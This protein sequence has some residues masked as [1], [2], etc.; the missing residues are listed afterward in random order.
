MDSVVLQFFT[1]LA[2][3][4]LGVVLGHLIGR[5]TSSQSQ[6]NREVERKLDQVLQDKK[7]YEDEVAEHFTDTARLLNSLTA[8]Y[9]EVHTHLAA[10]AAELCQGPVAMAQLEE[11]R[12]NTEIPA[13]L[14][15]V[16]AP[17][18]YAPKTSPDEKGML[19]ET[20]GLEKEKPA[21]T[22]PEQAAAQ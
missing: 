16:Q 18:D 9:R 17:L 21:D 14:A 22:I 6:K 1:G 11:N 15:D 5:R 8:S 2:L 4:V 10:G 19:N 7:T 20:F 12:D 13:H 3:L